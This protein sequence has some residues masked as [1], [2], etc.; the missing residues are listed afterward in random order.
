[1]RLVII[2]ILILAVTAVQALEPAADSDLWLSNAPPLPKAFT[3]AQPSTNTFKLLRAEAI[4]GQ[5]RVTWPAST[6]ADSAWVV[7]SADAPGH[8]PARDWRIFSLKRS[9]TNWHTEL[10]V[11]NLETPLIYF[12][13]ASNAATTV[14]SPMRV[15]RPGALGLEVPTR[16]FWPF[17]EGFEQGMQ[18][19]Q[20]LPEDLI[21]TDTTA[22][23]GRTSLAVKVPRGERSVT[24][25]TTR[26]RGWFMQEHRAT[27][28]EVW[29]RTRGGKGTAVFDLHANAFSTNQ[30]VARAEAVRL[31]E[32]WKRIELPWKSLPKFS[33]GDMDLLSIELTG[34]PGT[35]F[36]LDDLQLLGR[37]SAIP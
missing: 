27:G 6:P 25:M 3:T 32:E 26:L 31:G 4:A 22:R 30:I 19:W 24:L 21:R 11:D 14:A 10:P 7:A 17:I 35:E 23:S 13:V 12:V 34:D 18:G 20:S 28:I 5:L 2:T 15:A 33:L 9:S 29:L 16:I 1:M 8:W 37:W 36:L